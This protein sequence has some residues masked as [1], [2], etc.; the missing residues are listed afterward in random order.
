MQ[1]VSLLLLS[2]MMVQADKSSYPTTYD[3]TYH[4]HNH[5]APYPEYDTSSSLQDQFGSFLQEKQSGVDLDTILAIGVFGGLGLGALA[6]ID[7]IN[8]R[9]KL[10]AKLHEITKIARATASDGTTAAALSTATT[11]AGT[12]ATVA[13]TIM[14]SNRVFINNLAAISDLAR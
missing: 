10:C 7:S 2:A 13:N 12:G 8:H 4:T 5:I 3:T 9:N 14:N 6:W 1:V 11:G